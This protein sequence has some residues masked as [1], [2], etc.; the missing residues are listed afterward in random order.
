MKIKTLIAA[1][2]LAVSVTA[3]AEMPTL[4]AGQIFCTS[5]EAIDQFFESMT[6]NDVRMINHLENTNQ[7]AVLREGLEYS[8]IKRSWFL[9]N[10]RVWVGDNHFDIWVPQ[11]AL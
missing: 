4:K 7:C 6:R 8:I 9:V 1:A 2:I 11:E 3:Q 5:K 10:V